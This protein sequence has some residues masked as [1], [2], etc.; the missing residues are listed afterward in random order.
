MYSGNSVGLVSK[1]NKFTGHSCFTVFCNSRISFR[2]S[3]AGRSVICDDGGGAFHY[4]DRSGTSGNDYPRKMELHFPIKPGQPREMDL[5]MVYFLFRVPYISEICWRQVEQWTGF[6]WNAE[7]PSG[8]SDRPKWTTT[9]M[10]GPEYSGRNEPKRTDS[11]DF[12]T[13]FPEP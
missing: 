5:T 3:K 6:Y 10:A 2:G 7:F 9:S 13:K 12:W 1:I 8:R 4:A 11:F